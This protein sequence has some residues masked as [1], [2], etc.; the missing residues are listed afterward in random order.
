MFEVSLHDSGYVWRTRNQPH[1][2]RS[3]VAVWL[4]GLLAILAYA[5]REFGLIGDRIARKLVRLVATV[6]RSEWFYRLFVVG[7][8]GI[9]LM[10]FSRIEI[11]SP[12]RLV[13]A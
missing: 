5:L 6:Q 11:R 2:L 4:Q 13:T 1:W 7:L 8:V 3:K 9:S 12:I 10:K